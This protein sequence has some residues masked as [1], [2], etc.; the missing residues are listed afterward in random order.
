MSAR[1]PQARPSRNP[2]LYGTPRYG[3]SSYVLSE[4][5][6]AKIS[7]APWNS[8]SHD[9]GAQVISVLKRNGAIGSL[10]S[11]HIP[12][13]EAGPA[14]ERLV[15]TIDTCNYSILW[16]V[17]TV[18][19]CIRSH[20]RLES[21]TVLVVLLVK[22]LQY[23]SSLGGRVTCRSDAMYPFNAELNLTVPGA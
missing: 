5:N 16:P 18:L 21:S 15:L 13:C 11:S 6:L 10:Q 19:Y 2:G 12:N 7:H 17:P 20:M 23:W 22:L 1:Q 14:N 4:L 8:D 9:H 3:L